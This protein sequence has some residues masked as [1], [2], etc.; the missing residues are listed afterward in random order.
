MTMRGSSYRLWHKRLQGDTLTKGQITQFCNSIAAGYHGYY[1]GGHPTNLTPEDCRD[2]GDQFR[3]RVRA[4]GGYKLTP[5]HTQFGIDWLR[6][7]PKRALSV[8]VTSDMLDTFQEFQFMG[9][10]IAHINAFGVRAN[11]TPIYRVIAEDGETD[12]SWSPW[13]GRVYAG[14]YGG[15]G[16]V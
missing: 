5:E 11:I 4:Y 2:L 14:T 10:E 8:G 1:I 15:V 16:G 3:T 7:D 9:W 12:Y 13:Q 6:K